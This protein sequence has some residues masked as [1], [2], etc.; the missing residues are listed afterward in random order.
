MTISR[1]ARSFI[2]NLDGEVLLLTSIDDL[3][4]MIEVN[5]VKTMQTHDVLNAL[6]LDGMIEV[7]TQWTAE[8]ERMLDEALRERGC[9]IDRVSEPTP[10][11]NVR[12]V[13]F[14]ALGTRADALLFA[15]QHLTPES[16]RLLS[17][18]GAT[19]TQET[20]AEL[21]R[22]ETALKAALFSIDMARDA[23]KKNG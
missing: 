8:F 11:G 23:L 16:D 1:A 2:P 14:V 6:T 10:V 5:T 4:H 9:R 21:D 3:A 15:S 17:M 7:G 12:S 13:R 18:E 20:S 22:I 19:N